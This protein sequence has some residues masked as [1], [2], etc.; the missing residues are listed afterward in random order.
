[1]QSGT[2]FLPLSSNDFAQTNFTFVASRLGCDNLDPASE[3]NCMRQRPAQELIDFINTPREANTPLSFVPIPD[4]KIIFANYTDRYHRGL[5]A[6]LPA[7]IGSTSN[8]ASVLVPYTDINE[9]PDQVIV[10]FLTRQNFLCPAAT[11]SALRAKHDL[12]TYRYQFAG[13][14]SNLS[15][16][17]WL[18]AYH[19]GDL[20]YFFGTYGD[21]SA[22]SEEAEERTSEAIQDFLLAFMRDPRRGLGRKGW[23]DYT[24]GKILQFGGRGGVVDFVPVQTVDG[25]C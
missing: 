12:P 6:N 10:D 17:P 9:G 7:I 20:P 16:Y 8:E 1:M 2:A 23:K 24:A 15:P 13:N 4:E 25:V 19:A 5:V 3:L 18:G 22:E 21:F 11:T 14:F